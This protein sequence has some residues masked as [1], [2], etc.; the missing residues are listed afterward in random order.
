VART[1]VTEL[2][3]SLVVHEVSR[4]HPVFRVDILPQSIDAIYVDMMQIEHRIETF[5]KMCYSLSKIKSGNY[6]APA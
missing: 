4:A 6:S 2:L 1:E 3:F 5:Q